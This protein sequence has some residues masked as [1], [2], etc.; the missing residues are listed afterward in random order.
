MTPEYSSLL[1]FNEKGHRGRNVEYDNPDNKFRIL[2]LGDSFAE[3]YVVNLE[4]LFSEVLR[5]KLGDSTTQGIE[6]INTGVAGYSTDQELLFFNN[7]GYRYRPNLTILLFYEN[8]VFYNNEP[9]Y[10]RG[11]KPYFE[12]ENDVLIHKNFPVPQ[13]IFQKKVRSWLRSLMSKS[14]LFEYLSLHLSMEKDDSKKNIP[15]YDKVNLKDYD[16]V[17]ERKWQITEKIIN[18]LK[19]DVVSNGGDFLIVHIPSRELIYKGFRDGY[20]KHYSIEE[21]DLDF[22]KPRRYLADICRNDEIDFLS[23]KDL[24]TIGEV[25]TFPEKVVYY[26]N[27]P[28]LNKEGNQMLGVL[29]ADYVLKKYFHEF[30][31]D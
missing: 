3:G 29:L 14:Y 19:A 28:H 8:D 9:K 25:S 30:I 21:N 1:S 2:I 20:L 11:Y 23:L 31:E 13:P 22:D 18:K 6:I 15:N 12:L 17:I 16:H 27:D 24:F 26:K 10:W 5:K 7:E 4:D